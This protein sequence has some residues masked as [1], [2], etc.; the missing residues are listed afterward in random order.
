MATTPDKITASSLQSKKQRG[1]KI[2]MLTAYDYPTAILQDAAEID[3]IFVGD[4]VGTNVL[5]YRSPQQVTMDDILP[6]LR[7]VRRAVRHAAGARPFVWLALRGAEEARAAWVLALGES[8]RAA[9][10]LLVS[11]WPLASAAAA[12][13]LDEGG[14]ECGHGGR[15]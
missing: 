2:S 14:C 3:V 13:R 15:L 1:H 6:H 4:S 7:A 8:V 5:G 11:P 9:A 12:G 10:P